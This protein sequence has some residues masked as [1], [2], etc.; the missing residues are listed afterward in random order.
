MVD[1]V[2]TVD[3]SSGEVLAGAARM[4]EPGFDWMDPEKQKEL[5]AELQQAMTDGYY[6]VW[7]YHDLNVLTAQPD[8]GDLTAWTF[9]DGTPGAP[10]FDGLVTK[11][12]GIWLDR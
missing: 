4:V 5:Y 10:L 11:T 2:I 3:G 7:M 6:A 1:D 12:T 9:P 8:V